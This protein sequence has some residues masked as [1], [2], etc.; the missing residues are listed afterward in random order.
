[1]TGDITKEPIMKLQYQSQLADIYN[2]YQYTV[3]PYVA[4]LEV[5]ENEF[6]VEI[7]NEVRAIMGHLAKCYETSEEKNIE[8]N[9]AKA[10]SHMKRCILDCY[11]YLCLSYSDYYKDFVHKY[12]YTDL[13]VLDNGEFLPKLSATMANAKK[14]L[15]A[16]KTK[17]STVEDVEEAY[18]EFEDAFQEYHKVYELIENSNRHLLKLKRKTFWKWVSS[19]VAWLIPIILSIV[20]FFLG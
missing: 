20:L 8:R 3:K 18:S 4:Q 15:I 12:R 7:L 19:A 14:K 5:M 13:S 10:Q 2:Q 17:E 16:A 9:I 1:M 6:P 11:K